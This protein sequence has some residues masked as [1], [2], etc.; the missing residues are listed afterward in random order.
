MRVLFTG[1]GTGG[2]INPALAIADTIKRNEKDSEIAFVGT[3]RGL[4]NKLVPKAGYELYHVDIRGLSRKLSLSNLRTL[5]LTIVSPIHARKLLKEF[6]P[7]IVIGTGGYVCWPVMKAAA[8]M[9]IPTALHESNAVP[10][11]AV[12]MLASK[13]DRIFLNFEETG[14]ELREKS[15]IVRTG[16][17][18]RNEFTAY[19][20]SEA[21]CSLGFKEDEKLILSYGGSLGAEKLNEAV[22]HLMDK[23]TRNHPDVR[24]IHATGSIEWKEAEE[25]FRQLGLDK[26]KNIELREYIFNMPQLMAA[27]D[28]VICRAGAMTVSELAILGK[29][30]I[31]IPSPNVTNNHQY[32]NADVL[33]QKGAAAL[34]EEKELFTP[35]LP[36]KEITERLLSYEGTSERIKMAEEIKKFAVPDA[37]RMIYKEILKLIK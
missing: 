14:H 25:K 5:W 16:N 2:H 4:E 23:Y 3:P 22:L 26:C 35:R 11:V 19:S 36:L 13:V 6:K 34:I 17:P 32:K 20:Q 28:I 29:A 31:F 30:A 10:G 12:K 15:K 21:K 7:D 8:D 24:H 27:A 1:G 18:L 9:K 37:N 33:R